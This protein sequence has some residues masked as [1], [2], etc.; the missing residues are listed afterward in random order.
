MKTLP[1]SFKYNAITL[2]DPEPEMSPEDV[3]E[4]YS[5]IYPELVQAEI[6]G[7]EV[8]DEAIEYTF[9]RAYGTKGI[10]VVELAEMPRPNEQHEPTAPTYYPTIG[11]MQ[12]IGE[13]ATRRHEKR[14]SLPS[15][16]LEPI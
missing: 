8:G 6:E 16:V 3:K 13:V 5:N 1:R 9:R 14:T 2:D 15:I 4:F 10:S 12:L 7:P 11:V